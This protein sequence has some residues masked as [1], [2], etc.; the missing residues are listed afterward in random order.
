[1]CI[2][3]YCTLY[4]EKKSCFFSW[5][6]IANILPTNVENTLSDC[7]V[8]KRKNYIKWEHGVKVVCVE[9]CVQLMEEKLRGVYL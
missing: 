7:A 1:M 3:G 6:V 5:M 4:L 9:M 2:V 8:C